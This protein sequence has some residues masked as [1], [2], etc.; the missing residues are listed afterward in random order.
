MNFWPCLEYQAWIPF[1]GMGGL[2]FSQKAV[3]AMHNHCA[4][5][6]PV[7]TFCQQVS[8]VACTSGTEWEH[9]CFSPPPPSSLY[10][11]F[12]HCGSWPAGSASWVKLTSVSC[13]QSEWCLQ[14]QSYRIVIVGN[15]EHFS[16]HV[17]L[18]CLRGF[19]DQQLIENIQS[20]ALRFPFNYSYLLEACCPPMQWASVQ[21]LSN[22]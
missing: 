22:I 2:I 5:V 9:G 14:L 4:T 16:W 20:L 3:G 19:Y 8:I 13:F 21:I 15:Q 6:A 1:R 11:S 17:L 12:W 10:S 18:R 7:G